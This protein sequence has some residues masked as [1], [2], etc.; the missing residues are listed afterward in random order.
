MGLE[1]TIVVDNNE[2]ISSCLIRTDTERITNVSVNK[3]KIEISIVR[4]QG[5]PFSYQNILDVLGMC[6]MFASETDNT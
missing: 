3:I 2:C 5:Q 1:Q 6:P 4:P